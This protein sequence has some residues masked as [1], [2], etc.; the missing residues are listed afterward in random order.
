MDPRHFLTV[1]ETLLAAVRAGSGLSEPAGAAE[2]RCAIGRAYY[3]TFLVAHQ[4][5]AWIGVRVL[6]NSR[7]HDGVQ[8]SLNN[9]REAVL[10]MVAQTLSTLAEQR[11][12]ADYEM[13]AAGAGDP[14]RTDHALRIAR[15]AITF[16]D[17]IRN[18]RRSP[19]DRTTV[20]DTIIA[21]ATTAGQEHV[22]RP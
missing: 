11:R 6:E 5:L 3:A 22:Q 14:E 8:K 19:F 13:H 12:E 17:M 15:Q 4:C 9:S 10:V 21:W 20:A 1:A 7:C 18:G 2:C 16:L